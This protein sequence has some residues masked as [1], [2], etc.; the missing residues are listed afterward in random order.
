MHLQL[1]DDINLNGSVDADKGQDSIQRDLDKLK[2]WTQENLIS[3][4]KA[5]CKGLAPD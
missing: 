5:K 3:F 4:T 2:E 1:A